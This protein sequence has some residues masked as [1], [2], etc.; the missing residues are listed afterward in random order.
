MSTMGTADEH[1]HADQPEGEGPAPET[2][3]RRVMPEPPARQGDP[4]GESRT[5][6][7]FE[8]SVSNPTK[9]VAGGRRR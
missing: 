9:W 1:G 8:P 7:E 6:E 4:F 3:A 5:R 2:P